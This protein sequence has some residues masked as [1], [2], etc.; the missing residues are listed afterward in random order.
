MITG[1]AEWWYYTGGMGRVRHRRHPG[2]ILV[3]RASTAILALVAL[4]A[5]LPPATAQQ[6]PEP[7]AFDSRGDTLRGQFFRAAGPGAHPTVVLLHGYPGR[8][9][10]LMGIGAA[11][12]AAGWNALTFFP[13]GL[14]DSEGT[15][16]M[17]NAVE[18][19]SVA[20]AFLRSA[21]LELGVDTARVAAVG[22]SF[23]AGL[24]L[25]AGMVDPAIRCVGA[26][27]PGPPFPLLRESAE[28]RDL[29]EQRIL[30]PPIREGLVR[31]ISAAAIVDELLADPYAFDPVHRAAELAD[32][33][34]LVVGGWRDP[35]IRVEDWIAALIRALRD[36]GND[37]VTPVTLD[38]G[39][40]FTATRPAL[41]AAVT[42]WLR[43][44]CR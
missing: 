6:A 5:F 32:K 24:V 9:G 13:R 34:V 4:P 27:A 30:D 20:I 26:I 22:H 16:T 3:M 37:R 35:G 12:A 41:R 21:A 40:N 19:V 15:V 29:F 17:A 25:M 14:H 38:D 31:A 10:D 23:G 18:D 36:A 8:P 44:E 33:P 28:F 7:I 39:H 11:A 2:Y 42:A 43:S 1:P